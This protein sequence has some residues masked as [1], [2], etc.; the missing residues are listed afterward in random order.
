MYSNQLSTVKVRFR[1][2]FIVVITL[3]YPLLQT[4][5]DREKQGESVK[6]LE[7]SNH[8]KWYSLIDAAV[9]QKKILFP[10]KKLKD[11]FLLHDELHHI[12]YGFIVFE[13]E[14]AHVRGINYL[15]ELQ[16]Q[17]ATINLSS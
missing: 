7:L 2:L 11:S 9:Q 3:D 16:V 4:L 15:N 10:V 12:L 5:Q 6:V 13:V 17:I 8:Y 14:W 1:I